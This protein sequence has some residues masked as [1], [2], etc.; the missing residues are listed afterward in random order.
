MISGAGLPS[1]LSEII[2]WGRSHADG[3]E[4]FEPGWPTAETEQTGQNGFF[5]RLSCCKRSIVAASVAL[6]LS[7]T[8]LYFK[9][10]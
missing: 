10:K 9:L 8:F 6:I 1:L 4:L 3:S 7:G 5:N 2:A